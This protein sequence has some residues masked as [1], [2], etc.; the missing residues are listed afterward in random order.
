M[1]ALASDASSGDGRLHREL[2]PDQFIT[3]TDSKHAYY[4]GGH[5]FEGE[6]PRRSAIEPG[7]VF[8]SNAAFTGAEG[9]GW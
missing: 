1:T 8:G 2:R 3:T 7:D 5:W 9:P 4:E 6:M